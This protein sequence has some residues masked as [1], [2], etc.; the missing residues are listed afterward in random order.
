[1]S[2]Q[3]NDNPTKKQLTERVEHL[4]QAE[5]QRV[6]CAL[7][8]FLLFDLAIVGLLRS[9]SLSQKEL[10]AVHPHTHNDTVQC[11][12]QLTANLCSALTFSNSATSSPFTTTHMQNQNTN[13]KERREQSHPNVCVPHR[14]PEKLYLPHLQ[15]RQALPPVKPS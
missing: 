15:H 11:R 9:R 3:D 13:G 5:R 14:L 7:S 4:R 10:D 2:P 6:N 12:H 8:E 1:M